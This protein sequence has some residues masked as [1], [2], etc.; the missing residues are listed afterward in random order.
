M[1]SPRPHHLSCRVVTNTSAPV[2]W[3]R[4]VLLCS[5]TFALFLCP[6]ACAMHHVSCG[7]LSF[8][9]SRLG[10]ARTTEATCL[11]LLA[12]VRFCSRSFLLPS[13]FVVVRET[14]GTCLHT[15]L[16]PRTTLAAPLHESRGARCERRERLV[17]PCSSDRYQTGDHC[18]PKPR[19]EPC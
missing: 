8:P 15:S 10:P 6:N 4:Q 18:L 5:M 14:V 7:R 17:G 13:V 2:R 9:L 3:P 19:M 12:P 11:M 1:H 16:T